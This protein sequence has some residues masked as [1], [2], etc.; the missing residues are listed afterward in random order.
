MKG[1]KD[2][3]GGFTEVLTFISTF[4]TRTVTVKALAGSKSLTLIISLLVRVEGQG[5]EAHVRVPP[6]GF[7]FITNGFHLFVFW[8]I[9]LSVASISSDMAS[10]LEQMT[11]RMSE[12][13]KFQSNK[14]IHRMSKQFATD[15]RSLAVLQAHFGG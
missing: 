11:P 8:L 3:A 12:N 15:Y 7:H 13:D 9:C 4:T 5:V 14:R 2:G 10:M 6:A 1:V